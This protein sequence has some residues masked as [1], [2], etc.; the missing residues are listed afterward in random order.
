MEE[1]IKIVRTDSNNPDF[2]A[3]VKM[4]D[5]DLA[6]RDGA[7]HSFY[8]QYNRTDNFAAFGHFCV[9]ASHCPEDRHHQEDCEAV[10][11]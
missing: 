1:N 9:P 8:A 10:G 3:L 4:L 2:I 11:E 7:D 5:T 6:E